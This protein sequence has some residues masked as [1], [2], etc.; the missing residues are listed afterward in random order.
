MSFL[1]HCHMSHRGRMQ[2]HY[3]YT[4]GFS[5]MSSIGSFMDD[6]D[7]EVS[8]L[9]DRAFRSLCIGEEA[10]YNDSDFAVSPLEHGLAF[11]DNV[12][13]KNPDIPKKSVKESH[14]ISFKSK[15]VEEKSEVAVTFQQSVRH[16]SKEAEHGIK[17]DIATHL[18]NGV[19][20]SSCRPKKNISKVSSLIKAFDTVENDCDS[21]INLDKKQCILAATK[22]DRMHK[23]RD[24]VSW[25]KSALLSIEKELS[26][27]SVAY[28]QNYMSSKKS[29]EDDRKNK[30]YNLLPVRN[31]LQSSDMIITHKSKVDP[32]NTPAISTKNKTSK[33]KRLSFN[34]CFLHSEYSPF[35]SWK[36]YKEFPF[37]KEDVEDLLPTNGIPKWYDSPVYKELTAAHR[38]R[39]P[40]NEDRKM[41]KHQKD[42]ACI[43][44]CASF[45]ALQKA[46]M[47]EKRSESEMGSTCPPWR[48]T[49]NTIKNKLSLPRPCTVSPFSEKSS[50]KED[51]HLA[52]TKS[53]P[54]LQKLHT[55]VDGQIPSFETPSFN[56]SKLLTPVIHARQDTETSE[57]LQ[58]VLSPPTIDLTTSHENEFKAVAESKLRDSYKSMASSLL[59]NLKDNRKRVK[60]T[61]SPSTFRSQEVQE[62]SKRTSNQAVIPKNVPISVS[63]DT[64][65]NFSTPLQRTDITPSIASTLPTL[66]TQVTDKKDAVCVSDDY[67]TLS[68]P[69]TIS[70]AANYKGLS[71]VM[72]EGAIH[73][74]KSVESESSINNGLYY[75]PRLSEVTL[76]KRPE[77]PSLKLYK[78]ED[79]AK[80]ETKE[81]PASIKNPLL[82][83]SSQ[84]NDNVEKHPAIQNIGSFH[85]TW[86]TPSFPLQESS[87]K[88]NPD[89]WCKGSTDGRTKSSKQS[90]LSLEGHQQNYL[91]HNLKDE[92]TLRNGNGSDEKVKNI[93]EETKKDIENMELQYYALSN[94]ESERESEAESHPTPMRNQ[95]TSPKEEHDLPLNGVEERSWVHCLIDDAMAYTPVSSSNASSPSSVKGNWLKAKDNA[96]LTSPVI[97]SVKA[98]LQKIFQE[99]VEINGL[100][101]SK[102]SPEKFEIAK[103]Y[104]EEYD[105]DRVTAKIP[106]T[107]EA[108][109]TSEG[110][111]KGEVSVTSEGSVKGEAPVRSEGSVKGEVPVTSEG[112]IKGEAP[113]RSEGSVKGEAPVRSEGSVKGEVPVRSEGSVKGEAPV[114]SEGSIKGEAPVR[115][116]GS[117]KGKV[118]VTSEGSFKGE[119]PVR[120]EGSVKGE[121]QVRSEGSVKGEAPVRSEGSIKGEAPVRSEGSVKGEV[122]VRS[123]GSIKG[124]APVRSEGSVKG[125]APVRSEGSVKGEAPVRSEGSVKGEAQVRSEGSVKGEVP[126]RS[127]GSIKGEAPVR[128]EGSVKGE[129][130]V[131]SEGSVKGEVLVR[132]EGSVKGEAP[133]ISKGSVKGEAPVRSEGSVKGEVPVTSEGSIKGEV[134][135]R[136][137]GSV[138][139]E[140]P[141][142]SEGS[143]K[144]EAPVRSEG[145]VKGEVSVR[146]E[147][148]V[149]GEVPVTDEVECLIQLNSVRVEEGSQLTVNAKSE[150]IESCA[151]STLHIDEKVVSAVC[152][153]EAEHLKDVSEISDSISSVSENKPLGKPPTVPP[154]TE[155]GLR[156]AKKLINR[157]KKAETKPKTKSTSQIEMKP[158]RA[159]SSVPSSPTHMSQSPI[160][161]NSTP[162]PQPV[163]LEPKDVSPFPNIVTAPLIQSFPVTQRKLLQDPESGQYFVVDMPVQVKTKTFFDPETGK[164]IQLSIRSAEGGLS[165]ASSLEVLN[166]PYVLYP[167]FLP[168]AVT[169]LPALRSSSE[170]SA[171]AAL[172][173]EQGINELSE[174]WTQD[175]I[176]QKHNEESHP[177]IEPVY[178]SHNQLT[179]GS[180]YSEEKGSSSHRNLDI[181]PMSELE[182][183]AVESIL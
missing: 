23:E 31:N 128:S 134:S 79:I 73:K 179:D 35:R 154:K 172:M 156:R 140:V 58:C 52:F 91:D 13:N 16:F 59:F 48:R 6:T 64:P 87:V 123:K 56:I 30:M 97:K 45:S 176:N 166:P 3:K 25:D 103:A 150:D 120:N 122:L 55:V 182:D 18:S 95:S 157:R 75:C 68:S 164:Y 80:E 137:E 53:A 54:T 139:G 17:N 118:P 33:G 183:F 72:Q 117:V 28:Q 85:K 20:G 39:T 129:V 98:P 106:L 27:F 177:Y 69:Q 104:Y 148:S 71:H 138:K 36:D 142:T 110:S 63:S 38:T 132:S 136:S 50:R 180:M 29:D 94:H 131:R 111:V 102:S 86:P 4:D 42:D 127:E 144:G 89:V 26:E 11:I 163:H 119:A 47:L 114:R 62:R 112:S 149:K 51:S 14:T 67:L 121:A 165:H 46:S 109:V 19:S 41:L 99:D 93:A 66:N 83:S 170:M 124:E 76:R 15:E 1:D 113:V 22:N 168:L 74:T 151:A 100:S 37:E 155:K 90:Y 21:G 82:S 162:V 88:H 81:I 49:R 96:F 5:D 10:I 7:R 40:P 24:F 101:E 146:S 159:V 171:P 158:V 43:T 169:S 57:I 84:E 78:K 152:T 126:V 9:T 116:E 12:Q 32:N 107:G 60:S 141:V 65:V 174:I 8:N 135:V 70:E 92:L 34:N 161:M 143:I 61:Y 115:S 175:A 77:Y 125:E 108:P 173:D 130:L 181:I 133:V 153:K 178:D 160:P 167:G 105:K 145:S 147:G 2:K 44:G